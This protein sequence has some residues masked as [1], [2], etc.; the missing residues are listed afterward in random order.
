MPRRKS[1]YKDVLKFWRSIETFGLP[2]IPNQNKLGPGKE[3]Y[4]I[5]PDE[6]LPWEDERYRYPAERKQWR[7][8]LY[9]HIVAK[10]DVMKLL[11][12]SASRPAD[13]YR[14]PVGGLTCLSA[15]VVDQ[16]G[17]PNERTYV[18]STF[19]YGIKILRE[20]GNPEELQEQLK[21]AYDD[22]KLRF[23]TPEKTAVVEEDEYEE[24]EYDDEF[25]DEDDA[26]QET[27]PAEAA[28]LSWEQLE[29]ELEDLAKLINGQLTPDPLIV[30]LSEQVAG[31]SE[32]EAPFLN[33]YYLNDLNTLIAQKANLGQPLETY[34]TAE[35]NENARRNMLETGALLEYI[36]PRRQHPGR[37][38]ANPEHGLYTAQVAALHLTIPS[39]QRE[40]GLWGINGPPGTGKTTLLREVIASAIVSRAQRLLKS[41]VSKLFGAKSIEIVDYVRYYEADS[42]VFGNEGILVSSNN[43]SAVENISRELPSLDSIDGDEFGDEANYFSTIAQN[44]YPETE[45][46]GL[47]SAVLGNATNRYNFNKGFWFDQRHGMDVFLSS[48]DDP[49]LRKTH[50]D[51]FASTASE[52][53][54]LLSEY[55]DY[56]A[57]AAEHHRAVVN[58]SALKAERTAATLTRDYKIPAANLPDVHFRQR[59][60]QEI[61]K[62]TP[63]S[64]MVV[65]TLRSRIFLK[66][67]D[68]HQHAI[69]ANAKQFRSN[70]SAFVDLL[71]GKNAGKMDEPIRK[72]L[73]DSFFF[74]VPLV[75][76]TLAS[77]ERLF[78]RMGQGSIG[79]L[80][81]D[82]A[83][84]ANPA[85]A[86]GAIWRSQRCILIGDTLQVPPVV[87]IPE[88]LTDF[89]QDQY[90]YPEAH[91][92]PLYSSAQRLADRATMVGAEID[93][94]A[95]PVWTGVPLRAHRRCQEPMFSL[96]NAI[97]YNDQMVKLTV[98]QETR[99]PLPKSC[100]IDTKGG[101]MTNR[102]TVTEEI[103]VVRQLL[104]Q[105]S[106]ADY[107]TEKEVYII[108]PFRTVGDHCRDEFVRK[109]N[110]I[111]SGTIH[112]FQGKEAD[113]VLLV[114]GTERKNAGAR[115]WASS[116]PNMLN[117]AITRAKKRLY[118]IGN[119]QD[120]SNCRYFDQMAKALPVMQYNPAQ[121]VNFF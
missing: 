100:W 99:P 83:G 81:L 30:C 54:T 49:T 7:H 27:P 76:A 38:P 78:T 92:S 37:W 93:I 42:K 20:R 53:Q 31:K 23:G 79:W 115:Q 114:L 118:V 60:L 101:H 10:E 58:G 109:T 87:T 50:Q 57:L 119:R 18:R 110:K 103:T 117:V 111:H 70:L 34:L 11:E 13:E 48:Q 68:L 63:Y 47:L 46:W 19:A 44:L 116:I 61:H 66:S 33:S 94:A 24:E 65:N 90:K 52:L 120:W 21:T 55:A 40:P 6:P 84:Q 12:K 72:A 14:D 59:S 15:I 3:M 29:K 36:D 73:W 35:V 56:Q 43:N 26:T 69:L 106:S 95:S 107:G 17:Q 62:M 64:S 77:V 22:F 98:D 16:N 86:C 32:P 4:A 96:A 75:S 74:C 104:I 39:L 112:T 9:F 2:D 25:E 8:T 113:I 88:G 1:H 82:E 89:L 108:S 28:P 45:C 105:L 51:H 97:A 91:W 102:H 121:G 5:D 67:L 80:L 71:S 41:D 85:S